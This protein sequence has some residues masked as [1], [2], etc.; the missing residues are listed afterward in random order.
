MNTP[1]K[2]EKRWGSLTDMEKR[3]EIARRLGWEQQYDGWGGGNS[4]PVWVKH[5]STI[6]PKICHIRDLP[7]WP[8]N[9]GLAFTEVWPRI[10]E[11]YKDAKILLWCGGPAVDPGGELPYIM[12]KTWADAIC[13]AAYE[14][15]EESHVPNR[16]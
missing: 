14:L 3:E 8:T 5:S 11:I 10:V 15:L 12:A 9:D 6:Y 13:H 1:N 2:T 7:A 16:I 4:S